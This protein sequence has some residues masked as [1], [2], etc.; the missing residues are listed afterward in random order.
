[1]RLHVFEHKPSREVTYID[2]W[3]AERGHALAWTRVDGGAPLPAPDGFDWLI[4]LGGPQSVWEEDVHPWLAGEKRFIRQALENGKV[5]LG[6]CLGAQLLAEVLGGQ[7]FKQELQEIGWHE[8]RLTPEGRASFL[9]EGLTEVFTSY[10]W[11]GDHFSLPPHCTRLAFNQA[12]LN[13]AFVSEKYPAVGL[14]FHPERTASYIE[15]TAS[16]PGASWGDGGPYCQSPA[17]VLSRT[18]RMPE[19]YPLLARL[20]D[21]LA[22]AAQMKSTPPSSKMD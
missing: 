21:N 22:R 18:R 6:I 1:M 16:R 10:F 19:P 3:A 11:H 2:R 4:V 14:Q 12:C 5:L 9:F 7:A 8:I 13:Q 15:T 20:M 17:E